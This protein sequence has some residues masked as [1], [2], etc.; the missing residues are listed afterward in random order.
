MMRS[1][2]RLTPKRR[3]MLPLVVMGSMALTTGLVYYVEPR[4]E[5]W[6]A[7][8]RYL[9]LLPITLAAFYY[10]LGVAFGVSLLCASLF[11]PLLAQEIATAGMT[12][13]AVDLAITLVL[14]NVVGYGVGYL[15]A[16]QRLQKERY[17]VLNRLGE[18]L[19]REL[20]M[21]ELLEIILEQVMAVLPAQR[22]EIV[23][24]DDRAGQL[25]IAAQRGFV[26]QG[27]PS[28]ASSR[29]THSA[30]DGG[31]PTLAQW[32]LEHNCPLLVSD[33][34]T[35]PR[36][37]P[38]DGRGDEVRSL[39]AAPLRRAQGAFG[40]ICL[41]DR[42]PGL[43]DPADLSLLEAIA[44]KSSVAIEN[45]RL[46]ER[47]DQA[48]ARR[49]AELSTIEEIDRQ[50]SATLDL[51]QVLDLLLVRALEAT[52][53]V[54]GAVGLC[55]EDRQYLRLLAQRGY[56]E[57][58]MTTYGQQLWSVE[59]GI[60]GR[61]VRTGR[62]ALVPDVT[63]DPDYFPALRT[64]R[65]QLAVPIRLEGQMIGVLNLESTELAAFDHD[66]L[67]LIEHLSERAA[68]AIRNA[69][70]YSQIQRRL[71]EQRVLLEIN[72]AISGSL[73]LDITLDM[74]LT[75]LRQ[76]WDYYIAEVC[77]WDE[78]QQVLVRRGWGGDHRYATE[79]GRHYTLD[80]GYTGWI[81]RHRQPLLIED[82]AAR[83]DVRPKVDHPD[84]PLRSYIGVPLL[85]GDELVGTLEMA[86][87]EVGAF[88]QD[89]LAVLQAVA[90]QAAI[91]IQNA[92]LYGLT[93]ERLRARVDQLTA[94][95]RISRELSATLSRDRILEIVIEEAIGITAATHGH[96]LLRDEASGAVIVAQTLGYTPEEEA[97]LREMVRVSDACPTMEVFRTGEPRMANCR[98]VIQ[99]CIKPGTR[100]LLDVPILYGGQVAGVIALRST[101]GG[102][103][104]DEDREF[105]EALAAHA[106][107]AIGNARAYEE[108]VRQRELLA[109][110]T[111]QLSRL[112]E[113]SRAFRSDLPLEAVLEDIAYAIQETV[114]FN[115]VL[116]SL[117]EGSPPY[118]R[119]VAGAG[120]PLEVF[121]RLQGVCQPL[122]QVQDVL[123][124]EFR[125]GGA[126][127]IPAERKQ[128][129]EG[130]L[131]VYTPLREARE[132][133]EWWHPEDM[134]LVPLLSSD[135]RMVGLLSVD[136]PADGRVPSRATV[137]ALEVFAS[138]AA[139]AIENV[140]LY[141]AER[142]Q[143]R[144]TTTLLQ[145]AEAVNSTLELT[146]VLQ[147]I[148]RTAAFAC[149]VDRCSIFLLDEAG[150]RLRPIMSQF[151]NGHQD[152]EMWRLFTQETYTEPISQV[153]VIQEALQEHRPV[154]LD[155]E[156][157]SLLPRRW[158]EPF[159]IHNLL[160]VP[161]VSRGEAIGLMVLDYL[162]PGHRFSEEQIRLATG[163]AVQAAIALENA[164]LFEKERTR[165]AQ[166]AVINEV[167][168]QANSIPRL[169]EMLPRVAEAI[170]S[171][172]GYYNVAL[173][174]V[175]SASRELV[176]QAIAGELATVARPDY[177]QSLDEGI[178]GWV[179]RTGKSLL[180]N[181]VSQDPRYIPGFLEEMITQSELCVPIKRGAEV[182]GV[183]D[184]QSDRRDAFDASVVTTLEIMADQLAVAIENARLYEDLQHRIDDLALFNEVSRLISSKL[185]LETLLRTV[186]E[187][188]A[189][190]LNSRYCTLFLVDAQDGC[191][192]PRVAYGHSMERIKDVR[193]APG[194]GLAGWVLEHGQ[195]LIVPDT[196]Q[197]PRYIPL[198]REPKGPHSVL[199]VP[200]IV[201]EQVIGVLSV[202]KEQLDGFTTTD[203][204]ILSTLA[205]QAAVAIQNARLFAETRRRALQ[206]ETISQVGQRIISILD[207]D[208]LLLQVVNLIKDRFGYY[209][210]HVFLID[211]S[212][213]EAVHRAGAG[214]AGRIIR[215]QNLRLK[216][217]QEGIVG[218]VAGSGKPLL[219]PDVS[220]EPRFRPNPALPNTR[221][222]L[223]VPLFAG[224]RVIGVLDA[225]SDRVGGFTEE[226]LSVLR[227]LGDQV[228]VAIENA[229]LF[230][231]AQGRARQLDAISQVGRRI[232]AILDLDE[233]LGEV[234]ELIQE[235]F[236]Y[237]HVHIFLVDEEAQ[238]VVF[239]SGSGEAG[240]CIQEMGGVRL[241][242]GRQGIVGWVAGSGEPLLVNDVSQEPRYV[243]NPALPNTRAELAVPMM[244]GQRVVGVLDVQADELN[245]FDEDDLF[246]LRALA[247]QVA[248]AV[249]NARLYENAR[250]HAEALSRLYESGK[251][252]AAILDPQE[253]P[254]AIAEEA[255]ALTGAS[256]SAVLLVDME[257][258]QV[259]QVAGQGY[260][261]EELKTCWD[262]ACLQDGLE[263]WVLRQKVAALSEDAWAD[264]RVTGTALQF[265]RR[266]GLRSL[267]VAPLLVKGQGIGVVVVANRRGEPA[268]TQET[269]NLLTLLAGQASVA[270]ENTHLFE[271]R[272]R[273][274]VELATL[275]QIGRAISSTL[276][277]DTLLG[278]VYEQVSRVMDAANF[279]IAFY[280]AER[281][282]VDFRF[283]VEEGK[284]SHVCRFRPVEKELT[285]YVIQHRQPLLLSGDVERRLRELGITADGRVPRSW[286]GVPMLVGQETLGVIAVQSY[287][288][289]NAYDE[290]HLN[291]LSTIAAQAGVAIRNARFF[292]EI[293]QL[294]QELEQRVEERTRELARANEE[295][296]LER[297]RVNTLYRITRELA[298]SLDL[299]RILNRTLSLVGGAVGAN[300]GSLLL[301][302]SETGA[303]V[304][305]AAMGR[306]PPLPR[307]GRITRYRAGVG[308]AGWV[309]EHREPAIVPDVRQDP[310]WWSDGKDPARDRRAALAVPIISGEKVLGV[311]LLYHSQ[312][313]Y[314]TEDHL[315]LVMAAATQ[316]ATAI[317]NAEL[318]R[319]VRESAERLQN[320]LRAQQ[321]E[322]AKS[323]AILEGVA[324]GVVVTDA[325]GKII[326]FNAAA[327]RI[328][329]IPRDQVIGRPMAELSGLFGQAGAS[330]AA[331]VEGWT[332]T[333]A[334]EARQR[335]FL[336]E[337]LEF[338]DRVVSVHLAPVTMKDEFVGTVSVFRDITKEVEVDRMKSE[339]V[340][341]ASHE[342]RTPMT[343]IKGY[344]DLL[345]MGAM[346]P[347]T[348]GQEHFLGIIK[349]N[350]DRLV[351]LVN[352]LLDLSRIE[353]GRMELK[354]QPLHLGRVVS[355]VV[356]SIQ[357]LSSRKKL[358]LQVQI[359]PDLPVVRGDYQRLVQVVTNL[360]DNACRYTPDGGEVTVSVYTIDGAVQ[361]DV[362][363]TGIGI[364][365]ED[366]E[367]I[368]DRFFRAD[369]PL[370]R[371]TRGTGLGLP[372]VKS[373]V[374]MHGGRVW[375]KSEPGKGSTFSFTIPLSRLDDERDRG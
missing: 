83:Q 9:Y 175:D 254:R 201:G 294:A 166:L 189:Q 58:V 168:R 256:R 225:Q 163:I 52:G 19:S 150:E 119:R 271:E 344:A 176:L 105:V 177:R 295:L 31:Q 221:A 203:R 81:A 314:F 258:E 274:I 178:M 78:V 309:L 237:Y 17:R 170:Q 358:N 305:R 234:V 327:E 279:Y 374:E 238:E 126:Y 80:E 132:G 25:V 362:T 108:Q 124:E 10:G 278:I 70:L 190:I 235:S 230:E 222:E 320:M 151:A 308:L 321:L 14:F 171:G 131:D 162:S 288:V 264:E 352:D 173:L 349:S 202:D 361:V 2:K 134:L 27:W 8:V 219:V 292:E 145:V 98:D 212:T 59:K 259:L 185:E 123:R 218:W 23:L 135:G 276:D 141:A 375:V 62:V 96:I 36:Y 6:F 339:F 72:Q 313:G 137:E 125:L 29:T 341:T 149:R 281:E 197:D 68:I 174:L 93:D 318:Y 322:A 226:D 360:V 158:V 246:V 217:G 317:N 84:F 50:L 251:R 20:E 330:W 261:D 5:A 300:R 284:V 265:A 122:A 16:S 343:S 26:P 289:E 55:T 75:S 99:G 11:V 273:R 129:W 24:W 220:R 210:V 307:G 187:A 253:M 245:A 121:H 102:G 356:A 179:A 323:Q 370:V 115:V 326:L 209:Y 107:V 118:L 290:D 87:T 154:M 82:I 345:L 315:Q 351:M 347:L 66:D 127:Y 257:Q 255:Q 63:N 332:A 21:D 44:E 155:E 337:R 354:L 73:D 113:I 112:S 227:A 146:E 272:E 299:D 263:G 133:S 194:E 262:F 369:H 270:I 334:A 248:I 143:A 56:P 353:T 364:S 53:A 49:V 106:A 94:L 85:V 38:W 211:E 140:R 191:L 92:R 188:G 142:Q 231:E 199:L 195:A 368:F 329:G 215:Q 91:A 357:G 97:R 319:L 46:Y 34:A 267:A 153:P 12:R 117:V 136:D 316:V 336:E 165:A 363:D 183:L 172:F 48:L 180:V 67:R 247:A 3:W 266:T 18:R 71:Q 114:G 213:Q 325:Q 164:R 340:S 128:V 192:V 297:D 244:I 139:V 350:V 365:P 359:E 69:Q 88:S 47:T 103:F 89:D 110:R 40:L 298:A 371:D 100:A 229:R 224:Q 33:L 1:E 269:L 312:I 331:S 138:Q 242:I 241:K 45:V 61:V 196:S 39:I 60:I 15:A 32:L 198:G 310:R 268:F 249:D 207:L 167:A 302:D 348:E 193:F 304:Y 200:L 373:L 159:G 372:I 54:A 367:K 306:V 232:S 240:R 148:V 333:S 182:I 184:V 275:N 296:T 7:A 111:E 236:Q 76:L 366:Q 181:D 77:L 223:A 355:D 342:L 104:R 285:G 283:Y 157:L 35:D 287:Q 328:L 120:I 51:Q 301:L 205:D 144:E 260:T 252:I 37:E 95:Q 42:R 74:I 156:T 86:S 303:L 65:S 161:L 160:L 64:T 216:V 109:R 335:H 101:A 169:S 233:L 208:D 30:P 286:L 228:A 186:A 346:G 116:I 206:L 293:E 291:L 204:L 43:Y 57:E 79:A 280:D 147:L 90:G 243:P 324:D 277:L 338:E 4:S 130:R 28:G 250:R 22:G 239:R 13:Q 214:E 41:T 282:A 311:L 152:S